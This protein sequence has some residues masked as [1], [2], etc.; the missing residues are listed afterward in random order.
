MRQR[1][2]FFTRTYAHA[3]RNALTYAV[4][5]AQP[6]THRF[7]DTYAYARIYGGIGPDAAH[8][9]CGYRTRQSVVP[10]LCG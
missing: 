2:Q 1:R 5:L 3:D 8:G 7:S 10:G 6:D 4:P 9:R